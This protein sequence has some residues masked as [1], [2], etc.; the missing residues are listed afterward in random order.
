[1]IP[2]LA[3]AQ[4]HQRWKKGKVAILLGARQTGKSTLVQSWIPQDAKLLSLTGDDP[5]A[6]RLLEGISLENLKSRLAGYDFVFIDEAQRIRDIG[7]IAKMIADYIP[8]VKLIL[9]GSSALELAEG[10]YESLTGRKR[11]FRLHPISWKEL[12]DHKGRVAAVNDLE[13]RMV[14]GMYPEVITSPGAETEILRELAGSYLYRDLLHFRGLRKPRLLEKITQALAWQCGQEVSFSELGQ[15]IGA[16]KATVESYIELLEK[17]YIV[18]RLHPYSGN[19]RNEIRKFS[20]VYFWDNGI[21]NAVIGQ[22][23][24]LAMRNDSGQLFENFI[25]VERLK[26]LSYINSGAMSYFWRNTRQQEIDYVEKEGQAMIAREIKFN[27]NARFRTPP[28]FETAYGVQPRLI[29]R[30]NFDTWLLQDSTLHN[31]PDA[32]Q[33]KQ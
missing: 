25:I 7:L 14:F 10:T 19:L 4:L 17:A 9:T 28:S 21:R 2:R 23:A 18:F 6:Q 30:E 24:P 31:E 8:E 13:N 5:A 16:D 29:H 11:E 26:Q 3:A 22:F 32:G 15:L 27:P 20:K 1:M 12:A 33:T